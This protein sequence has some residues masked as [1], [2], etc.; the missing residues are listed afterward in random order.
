[1]EKSTQSVPEY[2]KPKIA[3]YGDL[4]DLTAGTQTGNFLDATFPRGTP[5][6]ALTFSVNG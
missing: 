1:M 3:D 2:E 5:R 6:G 4:K